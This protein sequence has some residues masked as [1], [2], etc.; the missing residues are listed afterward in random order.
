MNKKTKTLLSKIRRVKKAVY[1]VA[2]A[3]TTSAVSI[4]TALAASSGAPSG[5]DTTQ[6]NAVVDIIVWVLIICIGA[7][8]AFPSIQKISEGV[9]NEDTRGRNSGIAGLAATAACCGAVYAVRAIFF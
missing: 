3:L 5:V 9:A 6:T 8:G 1:G 7:G 2:S 4:S